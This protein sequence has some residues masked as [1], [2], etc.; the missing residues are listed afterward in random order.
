M[1]ESMGS[2]V[3]RTREH[4]G[5]SD[6]AIVQMR[7]RLM[8]AAR[9]WQQNRQSPPGAKDASLYRKHGDQLLLDPAD[10]W[11]EHYAAKMATDFAI[12][13]PQPST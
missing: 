5:A 10:L 3:D 12:L 9:Q 8:S 7:R 6:A 2:I 4:L 11:T 1:Q 13:A